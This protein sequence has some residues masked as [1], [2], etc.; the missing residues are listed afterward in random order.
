MEKI[1]IKDK[2]IKFITCNVVLDEVKDRL[3]ANWE[4]VKFEKRLHERSDH[5][6]SIL[7]EEIDRSQD[8][9]LIISGYGLCGKSVEGLVSPNTFI[10]LPRC[11][12]CISL[13]L[14]SADEY[15]KQISK[16][17]GSYYLTRG[18]IGE[19]ENPMLSNYSEMLQKY[20]EETLQWL[21]KEMLKNYTRLVF[22][23]TGNYDPEEWRKISS[24]QAEKLSLDFEEV[25]GNDEYFQNLVSGDRDG[26]FL[27]IKPGEKI[28]F[29]M[30]LQNS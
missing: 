6:R 5:L 15:K 19:S 4:V 27:I 11:D 12:D 29:E 17:P 2:K 25:K 9:G 16:A 23:N 26:Q 13:L 14:G 28:K 24:E 21:L 8:F 22:I 30:F 1:N 20:G 3:P 10:V 7:Q 18:Y